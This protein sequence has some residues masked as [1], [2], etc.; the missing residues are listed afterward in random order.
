MSQSNLPSTLKTYSVL[1][2]NRSSLERALEL[3]LSEA[4]YS[5]N[6]P[7]PELL[8]A[9]KTQKEVVSNLAAEKQVPIWDTEDTEQVKRNL[10]G[11]AWKV[12]QLSGT[13]AGLALALESFEFLSEIK[14]WYQQVPK[15][16]PYSLDI[17]AW[18]KGNKPVNVTNAKKLMAYIENTKSERDNIE[19]SLM[20]GVETS[21]GLVGA[22]APSINVKEAQAGANL[23]P[24]PKASVSLSIAAAIPPAV[25]IQPLNLQAFIPVIKSYGQL[26]ITA[27]ASHHSFTISP[28]HAKAII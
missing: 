13:K 3:V 28:V 27:S 9:Y 8:Y 19:L 6:H 14:S 10:A 21:L 17:V 12:R 11:N 25:T 4:L 18:E 22:R 7:Y 23:W 15:T 26:G 2:D 16:E 1:P 24:M 5:I 20:F